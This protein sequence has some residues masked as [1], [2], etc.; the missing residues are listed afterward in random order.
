MGTESFSSIRIKKDTAK[1][2]QSFSRMYYKTHSQA[3]AG[4]LDFFKHN[5]I[6]PHGSLGKRME[7]IM[8][9]LQK[10]RDFTAKRN[11]AIIAVI[12]DLEK[13]GIM[14]IKA[15]MEL[16]FEGGPLS[17]VQKDAGTLEGDLVIP[18]IQSRDLDTEFVLLEERRQRQLLE[19]ELA[20][21][22]TR[23]RAQLLDRAKVIRPALGA[24]RI[25]LDMTLTEWKAFEQQFKTP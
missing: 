13:N 18:E 5:E 17:E 8:D 6:S 22:K 2:F 7:L 24:P 10:F 25:Q 11:N 3:L 20:Q 12:K 14:P 15:M 23:I 4:M 16:L 21:L 1:R 19:R 9:F